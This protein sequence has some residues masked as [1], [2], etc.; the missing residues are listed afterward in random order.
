M[1]DIRSDHLSIERDG[2]DIAWL[3]L[4]VADAGANTLSSAVLAELERAMEALESRPPRALVIRSAKAG[5]IA[6]ANVEELSELADAEEARALVQRGQRLMDR[7][8]AAAWPTIALIRGHCM[9]GGLELALACRYRICDRD[10][11]TRLGLPEVKLGIHPG[12]GGTARLPALVGPLAAL[13]LMLS[14]RSV[15]GRAAKAMGLVDYALSPWQLPDAARHLALAD[16]GAARPAAWKPPWPPRATPPAGTRSWSRPSPWTSST[17]SPPAAWPTAPCW[18]TSPC[19]TWPRRCA[20]T[21]EPW[22]WR[23]PA[24]SRSKCCAPSPTPAST[25][26][27]SAR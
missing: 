26:S 10:P 23:P 2:E 5:F 25:A 27:R 14:G 12:F 3:T 11:G 8:D 4:D 7:I 21:A 18:T 24:A 17:R 6:G 13:D 16:P 20:G 15:D 22:R 9:G 1:S 19:P